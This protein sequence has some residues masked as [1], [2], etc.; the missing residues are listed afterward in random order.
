MILRQRDVYRGMEFVQF[1]L[2]DLEKL[3]VVRPKDGFIAG[4]RFVK[5]I[6]KSSYS[7]FVQFFGGNTEAELLYV[8]SVNYL[9]ILTS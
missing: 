7:L 8:M 3:F 6:E 4:E 2:E 5:L 9:L 1:G